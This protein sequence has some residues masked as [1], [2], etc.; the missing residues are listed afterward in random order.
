MRNRSLGRMV[1][2]G[3]GFSITAPRLV[4]YS[5]GTS[6]PCS[7]APAMANGSTS[8]LRKLTGVGISRTGDSQPASSAVG[9]QRCQ[10]ELRHGPGRSEVPRFMI[11]SGVERAARRAGWRRQGLPHNSPTGRPWPAVR[12]HLN[13]CDPGCAEALYVLAALLLLV[14]GVAIWLLRSF[15]G[16]RVKRIA[17]EWMHTHHA[18]E[19]AFDGPL[20]LQL[21]P[22]PAVTVQGVRLSERGPARTAL[23]HHREGGVDPAPGAA[24]GTARD[25][26]RPHLGHGACS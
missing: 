12:P 25:R 6:V 1:C 20:T 16:E 21:W 3:S 26:D 13:P 14:V 19:L 2:I 8:P 18:R 9:E 23:C 24:A 4:T 11:H 22:Q 5:T 10:P 7:L 17:I 15:D